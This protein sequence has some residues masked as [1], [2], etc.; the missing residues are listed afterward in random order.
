MKTYH[1]D[2]FMPSDLISGLLNKR[3]K[4]VYTSH[5]RNECINDKYGIIYPLKEVLLT[6]ENIVEIYVDNNKVFKVLMRQKQDNYLDKCLIININ[7]FEVI[8]NWLCKSEDT[9]KTLNKTKYESI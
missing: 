5:A 6:K 7:S 8:T 4:L 9:H 1:K 3:L 2:I